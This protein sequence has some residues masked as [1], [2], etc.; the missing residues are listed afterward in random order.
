V[1]RYLEGFSAVLDYESNRPYE[2]W[3]PTSPQLLVSE[4]TE[5]TLREILAEEDFSQ[6][7]IDDYFINRKRA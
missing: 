3:Y 7:E 1:A 4:E 2:Y 6:A 5:Q